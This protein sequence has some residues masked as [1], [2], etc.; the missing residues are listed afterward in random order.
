MGLGRD[1]GFEN[2]KEKSIFSTGFP[3]VYATG[4]GRRERINHF[5]KLQV[6]FFYIIHLQYALQDSNT[7]RKE[8]LK[9]FYFENL[10]DSYW[11]VALTG[12]VSKV[13]GTKSAALAAPQDF[14]TNGYGAV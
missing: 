8:V 13:L 1:M 12:S 3:S 14:A 4:T 11:S 5:Y 6:F 7:D 2:L 9:M 10:L